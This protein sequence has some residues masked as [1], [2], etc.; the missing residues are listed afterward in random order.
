MAEED[1]P[2]GFVAKGRAKL[3]GDGKSASSDEPDLYGQGRF[4]SIVIS[5][6]DTEPVVLRCFKG[7][8]RKWSKRRTRRPRRARSAILPLRFNR[9]EARGDS[10]RLITTLA[11]LPEF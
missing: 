7:L 6:A 9:D 2:A 10:S 8:P 5:A 3:A 11:C 1:S 4:A